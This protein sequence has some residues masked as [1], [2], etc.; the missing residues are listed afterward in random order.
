VALTNGGPQSPEGRLC[1]C[2]PMEI[3]EIK[4]P[5]DPGCNAL[6]GTR[7][8]PWRRSGTF[9]PL[10]ISR[11][12]GYLQERFEDLGPLQVPLEAKCY[13]KGAKVPEGCTGSHE[14]LAGPGLP[15]NPWGRMGYSGCSLETYSHH[16]TLI[17]PLRS[18]ELY[19]LP[20]HKQLYSPPGAKIPEGPRAT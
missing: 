19:A 5:Q 4:G 13:T 2:E 15:R 6:G 14:S 17:G 11:S 8:R 10:E 7:G 18:T 16:R 12:T 3:I 20:S 9:E 1:I